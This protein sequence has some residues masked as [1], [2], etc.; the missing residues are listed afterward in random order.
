[1]FRQGQPFVVKEGEVYPANWVADLTETRALP[2]ENAAYSLRVW[3]LGPADPR[4]AYYLSSDIKPVFLGQTSD[5][6]RTVKDP[7]FE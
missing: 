4:E 5:S 2:R 6:E 3:C 1:L 7:D